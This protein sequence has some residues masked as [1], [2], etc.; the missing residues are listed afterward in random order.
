[1]AQGSA[2]VVKK[3]Y[4]FED[5]NPAAVRL[6]GRS[7]DPEDIFESV[8]DYILDVIGWR[9]FLLVIILCQGVVR[10]WSLGRDSGRHKL[11]GGYMAGNIRQQPPLG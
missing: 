5:D 9:Y 2:H 4:V 8:M 6:P 10:A 7:F 11:V 1:M 3:G